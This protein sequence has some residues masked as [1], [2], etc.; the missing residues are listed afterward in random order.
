MERDAAVR[1]TPPPTLYHRFVGWHAA[2]LR[3][4]AVVLAAGSLVGLALSAFVPWELAVLAGWDAAAAAY[5][6]AVWPMIRRSTPE[7]TA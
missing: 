7:Q 1:G 3:R 6:T 4:T 2:A 5:L